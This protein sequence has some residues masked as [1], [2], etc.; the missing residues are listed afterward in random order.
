MARMAL[1]VFLIT[2]F[3]GG[4][5]T[6]PWSRAIDPTDGYNKREAAV[7]A[8]DYIVKSPLAD[9]ADPKSGK[10]VENE[11]VVCLTDHWLVIFADKN[12]FWTARYYYVIVGK[13]TGRVLT[14]G[15]NW[16]QG[17]HWAPMLKGIDSCQ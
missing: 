16:Y 7:I 13:N 4:C 5:G 10:A 17:N 15:I 3:L 2:L 6:M 9:S 11:N 8:S 1:S 12:P 14:S